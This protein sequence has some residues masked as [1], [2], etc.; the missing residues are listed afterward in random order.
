[1]ALTELYNGTDT[2]V[3]NTELVLNT[4]N[5]NTTQGIYQLFV[6]VSAMFPVDILEIRIKEK[7]R[8]TSTQRVI[9]MSTL[10]NAQGG[11][12]AIWVSPSIF[13]KHGWAMT[14][15]QTGGAGRAYDWSIRY[16]A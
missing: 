14:L 15:K 5:P 1:M 6:H 3:L 13:L 10:A 7:T 16:A 2:L 4:V 11:D 12:S 8:S 9:W